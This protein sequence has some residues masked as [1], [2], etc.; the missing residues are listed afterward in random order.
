MTNPIEEFTQRWMGRGDEKQETQ[1]FWIDLLEALGVKDPT[2]KVE[3]ERRTAGGGF[4]DALFPDARLLVEQKS[5]GVNL[6]KP[7]IRQGIAV[8]PVEQA[9]RYA[10]ALPPIGTP[11]HAVR[12]QLPNIQTLRSGTIPIG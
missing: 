3:F 7:E 11:C 10:N 5:A 12:M 8:T 4:I 9:L 1:L 2:K 6:D